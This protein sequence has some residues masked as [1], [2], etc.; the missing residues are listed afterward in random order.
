M[1]GNLVMVQVP[2]GAKPGSTIQVVDPSSGQPFQVQV[3][4][5]V[6][7]GQTFQVHMPSSM[8][9]VVAHPMYYHSS[10]L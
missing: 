8:P 3:P 2:E 5:G 9:T 10:L 6:Y 1:S 4:V 7:A